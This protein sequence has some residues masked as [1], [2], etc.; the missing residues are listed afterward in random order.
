M[1]PRSALPSAMFAL[2][3][4]AAMALVA[5]SAAEARRAQ[6]YAVPNDA[7]ADA[8]ALTPGQLLIPGNIYNT[9]RE[10]GERKI[11]PDSSIGRTVWYRYTAP[12]NGRAVLL[13]THGYNDYSPFQMAVYSGKTLKSLKL[14]DRAQVR[15]TEQSPARALS[16]ATT[17][18][19]TYYVQVDAAPDPERFQGGFLIGVQQFGAAGG[20]AMFLRRPIFFEEHCCYGDRSALAANGFS[21]AVTL[22][23][24]ISGLGSALAIKSSDNDLAVGEVSVFTISD[25]S[26]DFEDGAVKIG[27]LDVIAKSAANGGLIGS[28]SAPITLINNDYTRRP[29]IE[30]RHLDPAYG[31]RLNARASTRTMVRNTSA[32]DAVGCRFEPNAS[33]YYAAF[34]I[35]SREILPNGKFGPSNAAFTLKAGETKQFSVSSRSGD[36]NYNA[37]YFYC[38]DYYGT[39]LRNGNAYFDTTGYYGPQASVRIRPTTDNAFGNVALEDFATRRVSVDLT[40]TGPYSGYFK[41]SYEDDDYQDKAVVSGLCIAEGKRSCSPSGTGSL[42]FDLAVGETR[43]VTMAVRRG[44]AE[45]G[46]VRISV[47]AIDDIRENDGFAGYNAFWVVP[48]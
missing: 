16:F 26:D 42:T 47:K 9:S 3:F 23:S 29:Y 27:S 14:I 6:V 13:L 28:G 8:E 4:G 38:A 32:V 22:T 24:G 30:V 18:G 34:A 37:V 7:F 46:E 31:V 41:L 39:V 45:A 10:L 35:D 11:Y 21:V 43:R 2:F 33:D 48:K 5:T 44:S 25:A 17:K 19:E 1:K 15:G 20:I 36:N 12:S 40:N